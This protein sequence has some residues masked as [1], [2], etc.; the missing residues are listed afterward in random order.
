[1]CRVAVEIG[2]YRLAWIGFVHHDEA[3]TVRPVAWAGEHPEFVE[4][5]NITWA[6]TAR[7]RGPTGT[8]VRTGEVQVNQNA[9]INPAM[10]PWSA[11]MLKYD[12]K[13]S[14]ALPLKNRLEVFGTLTFYSAESDAF[15]PEEVMLL[16]QLA[17]DLGYGISRSARSC[18]ARI[19]PARATGKLEKHGSGDRHRGRDA[20]RLHRRPSAPRGGSGNSD[21]ATR[22]V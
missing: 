22:L 2:G 5:A 11:E 6:E 9:A 14:I 7:G 16:K 18:G 19:R 10:A 8:A 17:A 12:L 15:G 3:K 20:R 4:A 13:S 1:M 21:C